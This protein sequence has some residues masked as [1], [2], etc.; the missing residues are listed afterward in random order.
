MRI[1]PRGKLSRGNSL[2]SLKIQ[3]LDFID[4]HS[5]CI[6]EKCVEYKIVDLSARVLYREV[7]QRD[8]I[9]AVTYPVIDRDRYDRFVI[10]DGSRFVSAPPVLLFAA[11]SRRLVP[12]STSVGSLPLSIFRVARPPILLPRYRPLPSPLS[13]ALVRNAHPT[14]HTERE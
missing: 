4:V 13:F 5:M 7:L 14:V 3:S 8:R 11:D 9:I 1:S 12:L 2:T 6:N 10:F